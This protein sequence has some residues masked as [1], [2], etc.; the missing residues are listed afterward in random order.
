MASI[1]KR[2]LIVNTFGTFGYISC[3]LQWL[4]VTL[5]YLPLL[6]ENDQL[7]GFLLPAE[8]KQVAPIAVS[9]PSP[10]L[11]GLAI[12]VT[13]IMLIVT[14]VLIIRAPVSI[15]RTGK[16]VTTKAAASIVP[17]VVHHPLPASK[18]RILT[19][20]LVKVIKLSLIVLPFLLTL[21]STLLTSPLPQDVIIFVGAALAIGSLIWFSIQYLSARLFT[22]N[23]DKLV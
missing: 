7:K 3:L 4:F 11:I 19:N 12:V 21:A 17:L 23:P 2:V 14:I 10:I 6:L 16:A 1:S 5:I 22:M 13:I 8:T 9:T 18:K 20:R 15:A